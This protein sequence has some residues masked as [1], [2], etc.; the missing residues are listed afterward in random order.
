MKLQ[1]PASNSSRATIYNQ[2]HVGNCKKNMDEIHPEIQHTQFWKC[3]SG[4]KHGAIL[5]IYVKFER[6]IQNILEQDRCITADQTRAVTACIGIFNTLFAYLISKTSK[7]RKTP[8]AREPGKAAAPPSSSRKFFMVHIFSEKCQLRIKQQKQ[9]VPIN[10]YNWWLHDVHKPHGM[11]TL[12]KM[13]VMTR[14]TAK[15]ITS[16]AKVLRLA[17]QNMT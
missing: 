8:P 16:A 15:T 10:Q 1:T 17:R 3:I 5:G 9:P 4:F 11:P 14:R 7:L 2:V 6:G 13:A 12:T